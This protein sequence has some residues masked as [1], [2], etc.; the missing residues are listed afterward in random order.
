[1]N[2][3]NI[4]INGGCYDSINRTINQLLKNNYFNNNDFN[5]LL[6]CWNKN[7][8]KKFDNFT[9]YRNLKIE[10]TSNSLYECLNQSHLNSDSDFI[11]VL[12]ENEDLLIKAEL[13]KE[14]ISKYKGKLISFDYILRSQ[15]KSK[16]LGENYIYG[17]FNYNYYS[18]FSPHISTI[19]PKNIY[20]FYLYDTRYKI[21]SDYILFNKLRNNIYYDQI[22]Y[23]NLPLTSFTY[24]GNS[25]KLNSLFEL[26]LEH[27]KNDIKKNVFIKR[28]LT[29]FLFLKFLILSFFTRL[30]MKNWE[31]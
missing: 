3:L 4:I 28:P 10:Y 18:M 9:L 22:K 21:I 2:L 6:Y 1:M 12:H 15:S 17:A 27:L 8:F 29:I 31:L 16:I 30:K 23:F 5:I 13:L 19:I 11:Y 26:L 25:T 7:L 24:G 14:I 20:K